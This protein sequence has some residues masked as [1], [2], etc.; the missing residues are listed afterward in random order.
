MLSKCHKIATC[1]TMNQKDDCMPS[2]IINGNKTLIGNGVELPLNET[3][4]I[5][6]MIVHYI[7]ETKNLRIR[8]NPMMPTTQKYACN[9]RQPS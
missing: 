5:V 3:S 8:N 4:Q 2:Q 9:G 7:I 1:L 6:Y